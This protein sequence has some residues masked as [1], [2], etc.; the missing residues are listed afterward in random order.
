MTE[1]DIRYAVSEA[2]NLYTRGPYLC[3][4]ASDGVGVAR[5]LNSKWIFQAFHN[6][7]SRLREPVHHCRSDLAFQSLTKAE[8]D[9]VIELYGVIKSGSRLW[10]ISTEMY[11]RPTNSESLLVTSLL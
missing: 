11:L 6:I 10:L 8:Q 3:S 4:G 2:Q 7:D 9:A 1:R 5:P